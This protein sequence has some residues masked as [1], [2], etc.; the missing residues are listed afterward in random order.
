MNINTIIN[1]LKKFRYVTKNDE[2][3]L[4]FLY[5]KSINGTYFDYEQFMKFVEKLP[6]LTEFPPPPPKLSLVPERNAE[7]R[8]AQT[9]FWKGVLPGLDNKENSVQQRRRGAVSLRFGKRYL[10][11]VKDLQK[12]RSKNDAT[13]M[14]YRLNRFGN[15]IENE[16]GDVWFA[17]WVIE[18]FR[19]R[20]CELMGYGCPEPEVFLDFE[21]FEPMESAF[22]HEWVPMIEDRP[23]KFWERLWEW[24]FRKRKETFSLKGMPGTPKQ[25]REYAKQVMKLMDNPVP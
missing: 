11:M 15:D 5:N 17:T 2:R 18:Q 25:N 19:R 13:R 9:N 14:W 21:D 20:L 8:G 23:K 6:L 22:G 3:V 16:Y 1:D 10:K 4:R 7:R 12:V 24:F